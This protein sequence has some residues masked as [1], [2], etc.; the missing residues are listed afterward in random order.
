VRR[1]GGRGEDAHPV[2]VPSG[3]PVTKVELLED[4]KMQAK[5]GRDGH[6][7]HWVIVVSQTNFE[8]I[9]E[10]FR[11]INKGVWDELELVINVVEDALGIFVE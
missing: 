6:H 1:A 7:C 4:R 3:T 5:R 9:E 8:F 11:E 2:S 10:G